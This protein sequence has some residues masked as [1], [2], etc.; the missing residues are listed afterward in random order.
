MTAPYAFIELFVVLAFLSAWGI[1]EFMCKRLDRKR[2]G[3]EAQRRAR[4]AETHPDQQSGG[5][6]E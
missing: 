5:K 2:E 4:D 3:E 1:L 6:P